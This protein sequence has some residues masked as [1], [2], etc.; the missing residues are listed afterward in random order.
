VI[1]AEQKYLRA[2]SEFGDRLIH[3]FHD[4]A[5]L[6][7]SVTSQTAKHVR[8]TVENLVGHH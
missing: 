8:V 1:D 6:F 7:I 3:H 5:A 4:L 2:E